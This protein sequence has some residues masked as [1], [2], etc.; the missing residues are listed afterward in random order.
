LKLTYDEPLSIFAFNLT[1]HLYTTGY[2][3]KFILGEQTIIVTSY[4][5]KEVIFGKVRRDRDN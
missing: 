3:V 4:V 5:E 1:S 2:P